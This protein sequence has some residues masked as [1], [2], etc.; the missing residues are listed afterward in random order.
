MPGTF[1]PFWV[2]YGAFQTFYA[3]RKLGSATSLLLAVFAAAASG[4]PRH[5]SPRGR[6]IT[7]FM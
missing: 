3:A 2:S 4:R 5:R 1:G 7:A 6:A